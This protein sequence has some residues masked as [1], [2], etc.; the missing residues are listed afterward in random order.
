MSEEILINVSNQETRVAIVENGILQEIYVERNSRRGIVGNIYKGRVTR[1][2]PGMQAAFVDIGLDRSAFIHT[3]DIVPF[4]EDTLD[5]PEHITQDITQLLHEGQEILVQV[6]KDPLGKK[7]ARISTRLSLP[8]RYLIFMPELRRI[9]ISTRIEDE[10][11]RQRLRQRLIE[12]GAKDNEGFI[13]RTNAE[14]VSDVAFDADIDFLRKLWHVVEERSKK[15]KFADLVYED[16]P[17]YIRALRDVVNLD[18][19][20]VRVDEK[21][22]FHRIQSFVREFIPSLTQRVEFFNNS[23]PIFDLYGIE[24]EIGKALLPRAPLKCGGHLVI[25]QTEAMTTIDVN[26]GG[27]I[28]SKNLDETIFKTNLEAAQAIAKHL[29]LRNLGGIIIIDFIDM[30]DEEHKRQVFRTLEKALQKDSVKIMLS[31]FSSLGLIEMTRKRTRES[32]Q[33]ILCEP[34]TTCQG[35]GFIKRADSVCFDIFREIRRSINDYEPRNYLVLASPTVID[36]MLDEEAELINELEAMSGSKIK[37]QVESLY[38]QDQ[39]DVVM[40]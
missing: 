29:R 26:T 25:E 23:K 11:E 2:M 34:C 19:E 12:S 14:E 15:A 20:R 30:T 37:L 40:F 4:A 32:L 39:F 8:S 21:N 16:L 22:A 38:T 18:I 31:E 13:I 28:G 35:S 9:G 33:R 1:V 17:L 6:L 3:S 7:G 24:D 10:D 36:Y 27:F 5:P